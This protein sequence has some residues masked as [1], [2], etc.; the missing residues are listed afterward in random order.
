MATAVLECRLVSTN[1][2]TRNCA[3]PAVCSDVMCSLRRCDVAGPMAEMCCCCVQQRAGVTEGS[4]RTAVAVCSRRQAQ[5]E[6]KRNGEN[7]TLTDEILV[8]TIVFL[9]AFGKLRK[10]T[11]SIVMRACP[12]VPWN[13]SAL[14]WTI[15]LN[16]GISLF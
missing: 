14:N 7:C 10:A 6:Q 8:R 1:V 12:S 4:N 5:T 13:I 11:I 16:F 9:V 2:P 3:W 15:F